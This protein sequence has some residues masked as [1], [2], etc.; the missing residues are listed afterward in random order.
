[1]IG[2][3]D[4]LGSGWWMSMC[5]LLRIVRCGDC[6]VMFFSIFC[7]MLDGWFIS[8][9]M[10]KDFG[11]VNGVWLGVYGCWMVFV[12]WSIVCELL[13]VV[14]DCMIDDWVWGG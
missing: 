6:C 1:M 12:L 7:M 9:F 2:C 8:F 5:L 11:W 10:V 4:G 3:C 14:V 13:F